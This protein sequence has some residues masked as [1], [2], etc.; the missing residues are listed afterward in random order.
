MTCTWLPFSAHEPAGWVIAMLCGT[1]GTGTVMHL[2]PGHCNI[3]RAIART[4]TACCSG[5]GKPVSAML[6]EIATGTREEY[7]V[8]V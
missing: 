3:L 6:A 8:E 5:C 4:G 2:C 7:L 1:C